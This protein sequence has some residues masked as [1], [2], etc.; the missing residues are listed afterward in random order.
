MRQKDDVRATMKQLELLDLS[1]C[2]T[3][4]EIVAGMS[5][6]SFGARMLGEVA[7]TLTAWVQEE[8]KPC[9]VF[10][11]DMWGTP[12]G[13]T[14]RTMVDTGWFQGWWTPEE[15]VWQVRSQGLQSHIRALV[16]D[17]YES[18]WEDGF[19]KCP[20][21]IYINAVGQIPAGRVRDGYFPNAVFADPRFVIPVLHA[22]L[23]ERLTGRRYTIP[24][25]IRQLSKYRGLATEVAHGAETLK[26]AV[27]DPDATVCMTLSGAMTIAQMGLLICDMLDRG[28]VD[29]LAST[30]ALMAHGLVQGIGLKHYA[31]DP[32]HN[33]TTLAE[34]KLNRVTDTLEP[35]ENFDHIEE[36][37]TRVLEE[38]DATQETSSIHFHR[39]IGRYLAEHFPRERAILTSA[40]LQDV[41]IAVPAFTDSEIGNDVY[42]DNMRREEEGQ[43]RLTFNQ[44]LDTKVLVDVATKAK[45]LAIFSIGGGVPRNN[46]QNVAPLIEIINARLGKKLPQQ[47]FHY[48][49]RI[50]PTPLFYGNLSG[51]TYSEGESWR[52]FTPD[53]RRSEV[54]ADATIVWPFMLKYVLEGFQSRLG[55]HVLRRSR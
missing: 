1:K 12:L 20:N 22:T 35:E 42:V 2:A 24:K 10:G 7:E 37:V 55:L 49:C 16:V 51:C 46:T 34:Q 25:F 52:K 18:R 6:C 32:K 29:Y 8:T 11:G 5:R 47:A 43:R 14:L 54:H 53:G 3:V 44:E 23:S 13:T 31:Y 28:M 15:F 40:F 50:D 27:N 9:L 17:V 38:M 4:S 21:I 39:A 33:D 19:A 45:R 41:P 36:V 48:A 26:R 30:G